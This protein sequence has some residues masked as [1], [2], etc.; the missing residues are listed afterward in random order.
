MRFSIHTGPRIRCRHRHGA[1]HQAAA[2]GYRR[3]V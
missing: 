1:G 2:A 3:G